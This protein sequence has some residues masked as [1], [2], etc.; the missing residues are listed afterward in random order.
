MV[1]HQQQS[2]CKVSYFERETKKNKDSVFLYILIIDTGY[3]VYK[4]YAYN[5]ASAV[6]TG[7]STTSTA[8]LILTFDTT[9][10]T[11]T[12]AAG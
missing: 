7:S 5:S 8:T 6:P 4:Q 10:N 11:V 9:S 3:T 12:S 1:V 2:V